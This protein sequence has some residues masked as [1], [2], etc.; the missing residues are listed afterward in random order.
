V[1]AM[2]TA[3]KMKPV[4]M[5]HMNQ[6][7]QIFLNGN[8]RQMFFDKTTTLSN[9]VKESED[10]PDGGSSC[11]VKKRDVEIKQWCHG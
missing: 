1:A 3:K 4:H 6:V 7:D 9:S 11:Q 10:L 2:E 8:C 5:I